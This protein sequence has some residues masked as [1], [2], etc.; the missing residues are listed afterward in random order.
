[1]SL[2]SLISGINIIYCRLLTT[3]AKDDK[4]IQNAFVEINKIA[5]MRE[6]KEQVIR[7]VALKIND[8]LSFKLRNAITDKLNTVYRF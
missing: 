3:L 8:K 6:V 1:M 5:M 2:L 7:P 4:R